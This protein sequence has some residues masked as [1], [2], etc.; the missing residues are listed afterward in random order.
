MTVT[1]P[2]I[3]IKN[4][5]K[6]FGSIQAIADVSAD[7]GAGTIVGLVGDNG[8]GKSTLLRHIIGL[9]LPDRGTC[10]T[11]GR[12]VARLSPA[13]LSR[14]GYVHQ[15]GKLP[16]WMTAGQLIRYVS[17]YYPNW[18][19]RLEQRY[20]CDF[21]IGLD[22][23]VG[24]LSPGQRQKLAI[25]LA[26]AFEPELLILDEPA[27]AL[28]PLAR[29]R[30]LDLLLEIIQKDSRTIIISSHILSDIEKIVDHL[31]VMRKG[32]LIY[33]NS[34]DIM[35]EE[36]SRVTLTSRDAVLP[37]ALP[38]VDVLRAERTD[39]QARLTVHCADRE[40][41]KAAVSGLNCDIEFHPLTLDELYEIVVT[42]E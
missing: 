35:R 17:A 3:Q 11:F 39:H 42:T 32:R 25:L 40:I 24:T 7:I 14:I 30:F 34:L 33:D 16:D 13:E 37:D 5:A 19:H 26:I 1:E 8:S 2:I 21:D 29:S 36:Y 38:F 41:L 28:D 22:D 18:N 6:R 20:V 23:R 12:D 9:Y 15:E 27:S 31:M 4:I 10:T